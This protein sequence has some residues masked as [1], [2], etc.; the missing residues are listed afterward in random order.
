MLP[1]SPSSQ[2]TFVQSTPYN[3]LIT[4]A[5]GSG[6]WSASSLITSPPS[7]GTT[8]YPCALDPMSALEVA[9]P[10][11]PAPRSADAL[12]RRRAFSSPR[13]KRSSSPYLTRRRSVRSMKQLLPLSLPSNHYALPAR[14]RP[15]CIR[16]KMAA[17]EPTMDECNFPELLVRDLDIS[18]LVF[19]A[20]NMT[21]GPPTRNLA[22]DEDSWHTPASSPQ[23]PHSPAL[24]APIVRFKSIQSI[25]SKSATQTQE[26]RASVSSS[27]SSYSEHSLSEAEPASVRH[28]SVITNATTVTGGRNS[29]L[30][31][32]R[33]N[34]VD[35]DTNASWIDFE[36]ETDNGDEEAEARGN[37]IIV[38]GRPISLSR[39]ISPEGGAEIRLDAQLPRASTAHGEDSRVSNPFA[40]FS[41]PASRTCSLQLHHQQ[42]FGEG[43]QP[44]EPIEIVVPQRRSSLRHQDEYKSVL[45][46]EL[47]A[48][49]EAQ[50]AQS[51]PGP[52][53]E[54]AII[55]GDDEVPGLEDL[56]DEIE[57]WFRYVDQTKDHVVS[58]NSNPLA[59]NSKH[60]PRHTPQASA[61]E[62]VQTW[63]DDSL[64]TLP[65]EEHG[66]R[67]R[68]PPEVLDT[69]RVSTSCFPETMLLCSSLSIET[70]RSYSRKMRHPP[71]EAPIKLQTP[72]P[73]PKRWK[74]ASVLG[75]RRSASSLKSRDISQ[76]RQMPEPKTSDDLVAMSNAPS[77][78]QV[79]WA[80]LRNIFPAGSDYLLDA[81]YAHL[82][83]Y[84][85]VTSLCPPRQSPTPL[86]D[87]RRTIRPSSP[88]RS[89]TESPRKSK[90]SNDIPRKAAT[91]LGLPDAAGND[92]S[93]QSPPASQ[94]PGAAGPQP[95]RLVRNK[96]SFMEGMR[97]S[98]MPPA[99]PAD[100]SSLRD[101]QLSLAR[102][103]ARIVSTLRNNPA[104]GDEMAILADEEVSSTEIDPLL[105][106]TLCEVVRC[107]EE[108]T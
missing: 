107:C 96:P 87:K 82:V 58:D 30:S 41:R 72:P 56:K 40:N 5:S 59:S 14:E 47:T 49:L 99:A 37:S 19:A 17:V 10:G 93:T 71:L 34:S 55:D 28:H 73:S 102:C 52:A 65:S 46:E 8:L 24:A 53:E 68:L 95:G 86:D 21:A 16:G 1:I 83:A 22:Y 103:I 4:S 43:G 9:E 108:A 26:R 104:D 80:R 32:K 13:V 48:R 63:L 27:G 70:I 29:A 2:L 20:K 50:Q 66:R 106:R 42:R 92:P 62:H 97:A 54:S 89:S 90:D 100:L 35:H 3:I 25:P 61:A 85:Y 12:A 84:A 51:E 78:G 67:M 38:H 15:F 81:L 79:Q 57:P 60:R 23:P 6:P 69:L 45:A 39:L 76:Q 11:F 105:V 98:R 31:H 77:G 75:Q 74:W 36:P 18:S 44:L 7:N 94:S 101:L 88:E 33:R 64:E 91:L